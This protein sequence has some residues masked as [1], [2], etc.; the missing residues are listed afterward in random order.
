PG[1]QATLS[2]RRCS[3]AILEIRK[4]DQEERVEVRLKRWSN[5]CDLRNKARVV[6]SAAGVNDPGRCL[7][8]YADIAQGIPN[9]IRRE[10]ARLSSA[11][12]EQQARVPAQGTHADG[13]LP[14]V[15][16]FA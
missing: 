5:R 15:P 6:G 2:D 4:V 13:Q 16:V 10:S 1:R 3:G 11:C 7:Y 14:V 12:L 8:S 9:C